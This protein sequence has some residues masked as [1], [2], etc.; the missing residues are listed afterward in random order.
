[1]SPKVGMEEWYMELS[2]GNCGERERELV[3]ADMTGDVDSERHSGAAA[4]R[5]GGVAGMTME[6]SGLEKSAESGRKLRLG[7]W[8]VA[9]VMGGLG[10]M[11]VGERARVLSGRRRIGEELWW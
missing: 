8:V 5:D 6:G 4:T 3:E 1:M 9:A 2:D 7:G 11:L 10:L